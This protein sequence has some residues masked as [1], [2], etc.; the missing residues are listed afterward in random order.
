M[1]WVSY[2]GVAVVVWRGEWSGEAEPPK[3]GCGLGTGAGRKTTISPPTSPPSPQSTSRS[4]VCLDPSPGR[5]RTCDTRFRKR[6]L[7]SGRPGTPDPYDPGGR[8]VRNAPEAESGQRQAELTD[9]SRSRTSE[10]ASLQL[11]NPELRALSGDLPVALLPSCLRREGPVR[12]RRQRSRLL[13][14]PRL[15]AS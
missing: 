10:L 4:R 11:R 9:R 7:Y 6:A 1:R 14:F 2:M 3:A 5:T 8:K 12:A 15:R 13:R